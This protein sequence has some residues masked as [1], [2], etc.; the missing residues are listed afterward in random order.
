MIRNFAKSLPLIAVM[1]LV[2]LLS[3]TAVAFAADQTLPSDASAQDLLEQIYQAFAHGQYLYT[4]CIAI[5]LAVAL[6]K[7]YG[8]DW[9]WPHTDFG[10]AALALGGTFA[11]TLGAHLANG[12]TPSLSMAWSAFK[13]AAG[14]AGGYTLIKHLLVDPLLKKFG[15]KIPAWAQPVLNL[16]LWIFS[17]K[18]GPTDGEK[19][20]Q[21]AEKAGQAAV[22]AK[23]AQGAAAVIGKPTE[24]N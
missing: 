12:E 22:E 21:E 9:K 19:K 2:G 14:A 23:P 16:V 20:V 18:L 5:I 15:S 24:I 10:A 4:G 8:V 17:K 3:F 7:R 13:L 11:A 6:V 1:S